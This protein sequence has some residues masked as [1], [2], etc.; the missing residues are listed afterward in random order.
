MTVHPH[1]RGEHV[2]CQQND[3]YVIG[4]SPRPWGTPATAN[5]PCP[6]V[7]FIPTPVGNTGSGFSRTRRPCG[8]SP[9]PWGTHH[10][11]PATA[12]EFRFIPTPVGNTATIYSGILDSSVHPHARGEHPHGVW[13]SLF[14]TGSSPRPWGTLWRSIRRGCD[15]RFIPTPVGNTMPA[16]RSRAFS[17]VHPHARGE[18]PPSPSGGRR[19]ARFIPTPVGNTPGE[20]RWSCPWPVHPHARGEHEQGL[21]HT[22]Y[23]IGSSPRPWGTLRGRGRPDAGDRFIPTPVGN[24]SAG[25]RIRSGSTVHPHARGEHRRPRSGAAPTPGSSPRPWGTLRYAK[26]HLM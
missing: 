18:H 1:A 6:V 25:V 20:G 26:H 13:M 21:E 23:E 19:A 16:E 4:S 5:A 8:S 12:H 14:S 9:R 11:R 10:R 15:C 24:T 3:E 17:T 22:M 2:C 7:R